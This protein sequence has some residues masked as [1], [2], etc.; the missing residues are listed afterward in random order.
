MEFINWF[1]KSKKIK[2]IGFEDMKYAIKNKQMIINTLTQFEQDCLI[3]GT[4]SYDKEET[5][6][7]SLI[8]NG[9]KDHI[10]IIY[11][12]NSTDETPEK[13]YSQLRQYGFYKVYIYTGG[14]FEWLLLQDIYSSQEFPTTTKCKD[15]LMYRAPMKVYSTGFLRLT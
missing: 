13:K 6:I 12:K 15:M 4:I 2:N 7:N 9:E 1:S 14:L 5:M 3:Y 11:G 10:I 8:E